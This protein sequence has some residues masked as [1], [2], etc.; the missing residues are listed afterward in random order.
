MQYYEGLA[1]MRSVLQGRGINLVSVS[2]F[3]KLDQPGMDFERLCTEQGK[4]KSV[5]GHDLTLRPSLRD[6]NIRLV[7]L[8]FQV[9]M[10]NYKAV[11]NRM[12]R[13]LRGQ[14]SDAIG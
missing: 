10:R 6:D 7:R 14:H 13:L 11:R 2:P 8:T 3:L 9:M 5:H 1:E 4:P 12:A